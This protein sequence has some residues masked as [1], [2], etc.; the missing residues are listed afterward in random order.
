MRYDRVTRLLHA[1]IALGVLA[2]LVLSLAMEAP[3]DQD[4]VMASGLPLQLFFAHEYIGMALL[5]LLL[6]HWLW[7]V[8]G[9]VSG[10]LGISFPGFQT[11]AWSRC[12]PK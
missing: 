9:H 11:S 10:G 8:S 2:Q 4:E 5:A 3:D 12:A 1:G 7:S 6:L